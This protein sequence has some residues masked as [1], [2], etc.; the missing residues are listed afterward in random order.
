MNVI[1]GS[2]NSSTKGLVVKFLYES[3]TW[4]SYP[5]NISYIISGALPGLTLIVARNT[6]EGKLIES[7]ISQGLNYSTIL[8]YARKLL[9]KH[10]DINELDKVVIAIDAKA[11]ERGQQ[12]KHMEIQKILGIKE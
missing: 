6:P 2:D 9:Y 10:T 8:E 4:D 11:Y 7:Y 5:E 12:D 1:I 3:Q